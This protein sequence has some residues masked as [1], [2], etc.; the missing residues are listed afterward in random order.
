MAGR[1]DAKEMDVD[2]EDPASR[3]T[4]L[5]WGR[6]ESRAN[7]SL[8]PRTDSKRRWPEV[9]F[10]EIAID[11]LQARFVASDGQLCDLPEFG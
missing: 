1:T 8:C 7:R 11:L 2:G 6:A 10:E 9:G 5:R 3:R 4:A